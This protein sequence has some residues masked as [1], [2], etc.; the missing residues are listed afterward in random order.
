M[1]LVCQHF[2]FLTSAILS[3][4]WHSQSKSGLLCPAVSGWK[5]HFAG[6]QFQE[7]NKKKEPFTLGVTHVE[8]SLCSVLA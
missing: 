6:K 7:L 8:H 5:E 1:L 2:I 3:W 4:C